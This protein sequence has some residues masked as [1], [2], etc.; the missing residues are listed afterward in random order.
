[1]LIMLFLPKYDLFIL[2]LQWK[3]K[4]IATEDLDESLGW[5]VKRRW[6]S[7]SL[8]C[9][10]DQRTSSAMTS[11]TVVSERCELNMQSKDEAWRGLKDDDDEHTWRDS[12]WWWKRSWDE[13]WERRW[14]IIVNAEGL[15]LNERRYGIL[16]LYEITLMHLSINRHKQD[17]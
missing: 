12:R 14:G 11:V 17:G 8:P 2:L 16:W 13:E 6:S 5:R 1:M 10:A 3:C 15:T 4:G 7:A 9:D